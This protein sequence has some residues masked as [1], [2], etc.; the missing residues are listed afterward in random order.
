MLFVGYPI[1]ALPLFEDILSP[2]LTEP[3]EPS[4]EPL[5]PVIELKTAV[6]SALCSGLDFSIYLAYGDFLL[7]LAWLCVN[8]VVVLATFYSL[9]PNV[10]KEKIIP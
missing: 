5:A 6:G 8:F 1:T 9:P 3:L 4:P 7:F 2:V 10:Y